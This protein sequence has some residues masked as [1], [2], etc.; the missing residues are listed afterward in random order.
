VTGV[1]GVLLLLIC[2]GLWLGATIILWGREVRRERAQSLINE[3]E[4]WLKEQ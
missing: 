4:D 1:P 3:A 2:I